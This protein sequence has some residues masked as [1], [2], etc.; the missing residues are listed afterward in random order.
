MWVRALC[1]KTGE[2]FRVNGK[3]SSVAF[4]ELFKQQEPVP[5]CQVTV[6]TYSCDDVDDIRMLYSTFDPRMSARSQNDVN[7][8]YAAM[9][10]DLSSLPE[11]VLNTAVSAILFCRCGGLTRG[12]FTP[13]EW[14]EIMYEHKDFILWFSTLMTGDLRKKFLRVPVVAAIFATY[15]ANAEEAFD[16][17]TLVRTGSHANCKN[18]TRVL[19][20]YLLESS[21]WQAATQTKNMFTTP[22]AMYVRCIH[23]WNA[24]MQGT[25]TLLRYYKDAELPKALSIK[26][27]KVSGE[28]QGV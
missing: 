22:E 14:A 10:Q 8:A 18:P 26:S 21:T 13:A 9:D 17:W 19:R 24:Y 23:A 28:F 27:S 6:Q 3:H 2:T 11:R 1:R 12:R 7:R 25:T 5:P 20:E 4:S 16:F 15:Q